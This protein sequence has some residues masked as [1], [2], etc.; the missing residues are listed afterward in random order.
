MADSWT[1]VKKFNIKKMGTVVGM[2]LKNVRLG[3]GIP[4]KYPD[5]KAAMEANKR[6]GTL[7]PISTIPKN[8][9][10]PVFTDTSSVYEHIEAYD[11]GVY[12]SDGRKVS[13]PKAQKYFGWGETLNG[14]R[15]VKKVK[16]TEP[17]TS[18]V[19][20][21]KVAKIK[22]GD[23]V[24][25]NGAGTGNSQGGGGK[26]K[27][28]KN[29]KMRVIVVQNGRYGCNQYNKKGAVTGFWTSK[30]VKKA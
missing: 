16:T 12:Y 1:Q 24:I 6:A 27:S 29:Q 25:V 11:K 18:K 17:K 3:F 7:H 8:C 26:T 30:Q 23:T 2:C 21:D 19:A 10:V 20:K 22:V 15:V 9:Q 4:S 28:F 5:A 14:V 13:N